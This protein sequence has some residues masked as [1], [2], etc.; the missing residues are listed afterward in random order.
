MI[1]DWL[2]LVISAAYSSNVILGAVGYVP[3]LLTLWWA[4]RA[5]QN[6]DISAISLR[7]FSIWSIG[8]LNT[9]L[10]GLIV[11][12]SWIMVFVGGST[13]VLNLAVITLVKLIQFQNKNLSQ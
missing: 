7:S 4:Y 3:Q 11:T 13:L 6:C 1:S 12:Q 2:I 10:F 8:A 9:T 5:N